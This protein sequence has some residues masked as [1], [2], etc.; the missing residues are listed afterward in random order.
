M[1][2]ARRR[3]PL[4][5]QPLEGESIDSWLE[6]S[7]LAMG[8]TVGTLAA[9][10]DLPATSMPTW[11]VWLSPAQSQSLAAATGAPPESLEAMTL[12][13]YEGV[14]LRLNSESRRLE[15][16]FPFGPLSWSRFCPACLRETG[17]RWQ[18]R[19]RLGWSFAC[20]QHNCLLVDVCPGCGSHQR[21]TQSYR[22]RP[23]PAAC[24]CGD[25]LNMAPTLRLFGDDHSFLWAQR[26]VYDFIETGAAGF[27][28]FQ[29]H[30]QPQ[31]EVLAAVRSLANRTLNLASKRIFVITK[32][33]DESTRQVTRPTK[34][35]LIGDPLPTSTRGWRA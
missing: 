15:P 35:S 19:W 14:A 5:V 34:R 25:A 22:R 30:P 11:K 4:Q 17:G 9:A 1:R 26:I 31:P 24:G 18:L 27:G 28:V 20:V 8:I 7:A 10:A 2:V 29:E 6:A 12:S 21:S 32:L 13:K 33:V 3:L 23:S 16:D